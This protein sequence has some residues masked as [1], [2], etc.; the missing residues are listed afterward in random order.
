MLYCGNDQLIRL[1]G[2]AIEG[3]LR[4]LMGAQDRYDGNHPLEFSYLPTADGARRRAFT[5]G[6]YCN[7]WSLT[8]TPSI[9]WCWIEAADDRI[10]VELRVRAVPL[11][12]AVY[13]VTLD[14]TITLEV[15]P[16]GTILRPHLNVDVHTESHVGPEAG[17][18]IAAVAIA[19]SVILQPL[20]GLAAT[21]MA[22]VPAIIKD[23]AS[24]AINDQVASAD[25]SNRGAI[26]LAAMPLFDMTFGSVNVSGSG[27]LVIGVNIRPWP[28][29]PAAV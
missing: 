12:D 2:G 11:L 18:T 10:N 13:Y 7:F 21:V 26:D 22:A 19:G 27:D 3:A 14:A 17:V 20:L 24:K 8:F 1:L 9:D 28:G 16:G 23:L 5:D 29:A 15:D 4:Q 25:V 6:N